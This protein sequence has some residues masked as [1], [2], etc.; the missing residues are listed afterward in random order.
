M[1]K[2]QFKGGFTV[3]DNDEP[4]F[5]IEWLFD[6]RETDPN[7][8]QFLAYDANLWPMPDFDTWTDKDFKKKN[9]EIA[10]NVTHDFTGEVWL[11]DTKIK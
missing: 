6:E 10:L 5:S 2:S 7:K 1:D 11:D 3:R 4:M 9:I 8:L